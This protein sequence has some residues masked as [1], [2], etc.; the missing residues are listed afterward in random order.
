MASAKK[1]GSRT[2]NWL[3]T[4]VPMM[5]IC[6]GNTEGREWEELLPCIQEVPGS[7]LSYAVVL[8]AFPVPSDKCRDGAVAKAAM[9]H[10]LS[11]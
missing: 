10:V 4:H 3:R 1:S 11:E 9:V 2:S 8:R 6:Q 5:L 7:Y